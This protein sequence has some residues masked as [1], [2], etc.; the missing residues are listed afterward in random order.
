[1]NAQLLK[2]CEEAFSYNTLVKCLQILESRD[3]KLNSG[4]VI[5]E[6]QIEVEPSEARIREIIKD[7][8]GQFIPKEKQQQPIIQTKEEI[9]FVKTEDFLGR[10]YQLLYG[11]GDY[12]EALK[13]LRDLDAKGD[14]NA[15][16]TIG[17]MH[18]EGM[19]VKKDLHLATTYFEK[20]NTAGNLEARYRLAVLYEVR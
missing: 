18:L 9:R 8:I 19:G 10:A 16:A 12:Y 2:A 5:I 17:I 20:A 15:Q 6:K 7:N 14:A 13:I 3:I 11:Q 4:E 1:M